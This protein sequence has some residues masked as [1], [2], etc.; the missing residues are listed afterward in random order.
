MQDMYDAYIAT[1]LE[2]LSKHIY[3]S[4]FI[5]EN[6]LFQAQML[7]FNATIYVCYFITENMLTKQFW[8]IQLRKF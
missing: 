1:L 2:R 5:A 6:M 7:C 8:D 4:V 3:S